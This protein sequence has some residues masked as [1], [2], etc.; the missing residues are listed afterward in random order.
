MRRSRQAQTHKHKHTHK[1]ICTHASTVCTHASTNPYAYTYV[2]AQ[3][4]RHTG[5]PISTQQK[6]THTHEP[7]RTYSAHT[8]INK[9]TTQTHLLTSTRLT[10]K[11]KHKT[12]TPPPI[13]C[14]HRFP[15][16]L[17][18]R[19]SIDLRT[20]SVLV[21][22]C[23]SISAIVRDSRGSGTLIHVGEGSVVITD[24]AAGD[25]HAKGGGSFKTASAQRPLKAWWGR[26]GAG[27]VFEGREA[28]DLLLSLLAS[29]LQHGTAHARETNPPQEAERGSENTRAA[30][31]DEC[32][33]DE[34]QD[35]QSYGPDL[36]ACV[37]AQF[38]T[39]LTLH[40]VG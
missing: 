18:Q 36:R 32:N 33:E 20:R 39:C 5:T 15:P 40:L 21:V 25:W 28:C 27:R 35:E 9:P 19:E 22:L 16:L 13:P 26:A 31:G 34:A 11:T 38:E 3:T 29:T 1:S 23:G 8:N 24:L 12:G 6:H 30:A 4:Y 14:A 10:R 37:K 7:T 17:S 2:C